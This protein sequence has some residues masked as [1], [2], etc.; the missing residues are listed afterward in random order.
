MRA[1]LATL[2]VRAACEMLQ[3]HPGAHFVLLNTDRHPNTCGDR[4]GRVEPFFVLEH[5]AARSTQSFTWEEARA[6]GFGT[7]V[8]EHVAHLIGWSVEPFAVAI[9]NQ[10]LVP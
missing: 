9:A 3:D 1:R 8:P 7:P 4:M 2:L 5:S 6:M 10:H